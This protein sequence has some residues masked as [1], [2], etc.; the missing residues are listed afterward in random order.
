[1]RKRYIGAG[2]L[3]G[4]AVIENPY[5]LIF[6]IYFVILMIEKKITWNQAAK[7]CLGGLISAGYFMFIFFSRITW[8]D[9]Q[10]FF[11]VWNSYLQSAGGLTR[12]FGGFLRAFVDYFGAIDILMWI[13]L[14][15]LTIAY[16]FY[17]YYRGEIICYGLSA[18]F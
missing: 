9:L 12:T 15:I 10:S 5:L 14:L 4:L 8:H 2:V 3:Y 11:P 17:E 13:A 7:F 1:M 18:I 16:S 6:G